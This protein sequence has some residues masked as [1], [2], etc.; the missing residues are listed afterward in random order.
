MTTIL[1]CRVATDATFFTFSNSCFWHIGDIRNCSRGSHIV[2]NRQTDIFSGVH[3]VV[4]GR[5]G[6]WRFPPP[7]FKYAHARTPARAHLNQIH[8]NQMQM[9]I[10]KRTQQGNQ[11]QV[12][13]QM[14]HLLQMHLSTVL[15]QIRL[16]FSMSIY[17]RRRWSN[18][19]LASFTDATS[20][21]VWRWTYNN[22]STSFCSLQQTM[23]YTVGEIG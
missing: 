15:L 10:K 5:L 17:N 9:K 19:Y 4:V 14:L 6:R 7:P 8:L 23:T 2:Y 12:Q 11:M 16:R 18:S 13:M 1:W 3:F 21:R 20:S 22:C